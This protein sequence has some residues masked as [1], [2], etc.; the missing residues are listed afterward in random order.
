MDRLCLL[1]AGTAGWTGRFEVDDKLLAG[2]F[3][4]DSF[5]ALPQR[6]RKGK[7]GLGTNRPNC[8]GYRVNY[9]QKS[10]AKRRGNYISG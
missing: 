1:S 10:P 5:K 9:N 8:E 3:G 6:Y 4:V 7:L 2:L